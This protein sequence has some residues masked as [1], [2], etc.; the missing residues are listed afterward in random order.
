MWE[1]EPPG[2]RPERGAPKDPD[3]G[4][5]G[6]RHENAPALARW[7]GRWRPAHTHLRVPGSN[8]HGLAV[9]NWRS[10]PPSPI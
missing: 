7:T 4:A 6:P 8:A 2:V 10:C 3:A 5:R 9:P 1:P